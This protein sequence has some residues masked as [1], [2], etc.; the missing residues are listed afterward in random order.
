MNEGR[1]LDKAQDLL[2]QQKYTQGL[3]LLDS[4]LPADHEEANWMRLEALVGLGWSDEAE[5]LFLDRLR[6]GGDGAEA[7]NRMAYLFLGAESYA[8]AERILEIAMQ[9]WPDNVPLRLTMA[10]VYF[11]TDRRQQAES[12]ARLEG[13]DLSVEDLLERANTFNSW[14][15]IPDEQDEVVV[16]QRAI[17]YVRRFLELALT[18]LD[19]AIDSG[20]ES[21][22]L[23]RR[24]E[25]LANIGEFER[26]A[27]DV[28]QLIASMD[29]DHPALE[30]LEQRRDEFAAGPDGERQKLANML[31]NVY[32]EEG[33]RGNRTAQE[34]L[35]R[36]VL[37]V[38]AERIL[39]GQDLQSAL[40]DIDAEDE[41]VW[42]AL[43][44][45][46]QLHGLSQQPAP[47]W[48]RVDCKDYPSV[49][50]RWANKVRKEL[51]RNGFR[52]LGDYEDQNLIEQLGQRVFVRLMVDQSGTTAAAVYAL[53]VPWPGLMGWLKMLLAGAPRLY[54]IVE[55]ESA[56]QGDRFLISNNAGSA[57]PFGY[58]DVVVKQSLPLRVNLSQVMQAHQAALQ[59]LVESGQILQDISSIEVLMALQDKQRQ[60]KNEY[61]RS[62]GYVTDQELEALLGERYS[63]LETLVREKLSEI[64]ALQPS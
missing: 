49:A 60:A 39:A 62:I 24:A 16:G 35:A 54:R 36:D 17:R 15:M 3:R 1:L 22:L 46:Q 56:L 42:V 59:A 20:G 34:G 58:G 50:V 19:A 21:Q 40:A 30:I 48:R 25:V 52:N 28:D 23:L 26:A 51:E 45:A 5:K 33:Q 64:V 6:S 4:N 9:D 57:D 18:D 63:E 47:D 44:I 2:D 8:Q 41:A 38:A 14:A 37:E 11:Q 61:R 13:L 31:R 7:C 43:S 55:L 10:D 29:A 27:R 53:R 12:L 32:R